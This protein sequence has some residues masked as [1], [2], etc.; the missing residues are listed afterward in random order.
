[1]L[2]GLRIAEGRDAVR[3]YMATLGKRPGFNV[4]FTLEKANGFC[5]WKAGV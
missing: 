1:M 2:R 3:D 4:S 5:R